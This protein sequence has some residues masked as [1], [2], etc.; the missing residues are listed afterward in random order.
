MNKWRVLLEYIDY[1]VYSKEDEQ[2]QI[3]E[4]TEKEMAESLYKQFVQTH[5]ISGD[6]LW[7]FDISL[8]CLRKM[9]KKDRNYLAEHTDYNDYHFGYAMYIRNNYIHGSKKRF[10]LMADDTSFQVMEYMFSILS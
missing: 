2:I 9:S 6:D 8:D 7:A 3:Q 4:G 5:D 1:Y 10:V